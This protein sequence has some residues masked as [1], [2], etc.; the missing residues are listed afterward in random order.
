MTGTEF[1]VEALKLYPDSRRVLLTAYADTQT[2]IAGINTVGLDYYLLKPW[3]PPEERLYPILDELLEDWK[4]HVRL[5]YEGIRVAGTLWS[6]TSHEAKDFLTR[7]Q[8]K[9]VFGSDCSDVDDRGP[10]CQG[11]QTIATVRRLAAS[12][13]IERK[14]LYENA[15]R[16]FTL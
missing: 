8:N 10:K 5:P 14:L 1:L 2:A 11:A 3:E 6:L 13:T 16:L 12:R 9:L 4:A 7:H 15:K